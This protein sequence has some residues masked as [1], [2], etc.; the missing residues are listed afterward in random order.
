MSNTKPYIQAG[1]LLLV[2]VVAMAG[3]WQYAQ[4]EL[5]S[6]DIE[7]TLQPMAALLDNNLKI[8]SDLKVEGLAD[9]DSVLL[10]TYLARIRADSVPKHAVLK[11]RIDALVNNNTA[12]V[13]LLARYAPR[14]RTSAF[15]AGAET[16]RDYASR[17]RDRWQSVF[18]IFMAGGHLPVAGPAFPTAFADALAA[19][20]AA[21]Q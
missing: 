18:E 3:T 9:S 8:L 11:Q 5:R 16:F 15:R 21:V 7:D 20:R 14:A 10:D 19:E 12:I 17:L 4:A 6:R 2:M 1:L 13:T